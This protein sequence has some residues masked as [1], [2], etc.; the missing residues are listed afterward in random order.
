MSQRY[1]FLIITNHHQH[2][3]SN[4]IYSLGAELATRPEIIGIDVVSRGNPNNAEFFNSHTLN[5]QCARIDARFS[6]IP[7]GEQFLKD[8]RKGNLTDYDVVLMRLARPVDTSFFHFIARKTVGKVVINHPLGI[9]KTSNKAFL[10]HFPDLCPPMRLCHQ[11][12][13]ILSFAEQFSIVLKPLKEY[14][15]RGILRITDGKLYDQDQLYEAV[16]YLD[17]HKNYIES[18]GYLAMKFMKNVG[19]GDKRIIVVGGE[20]MAASLRMPP[21]G[22]WLCNVSQGGR[23]LPAEP[24]PEE[25]EMI[26]KISPVLINEGIFIYGADTLVNDEGKRI[27]SEINTLSV[28]GFTDIQQQTGL[29]IVSRTIELIMNYVNQKYSN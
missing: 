25:L 4:P 10:Q 14:G 1:R 26:E 6:F 28:G 9:E 21:E 11:V 18:S 7:D 12:D 2:K 15:G 3:P 13:D 20:I 22:S 23:S 17:R 8:Q 27:L 29:P 24:E 16:E 19:Q 5:F